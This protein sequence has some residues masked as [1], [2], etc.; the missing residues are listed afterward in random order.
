MRALNI[1][2]S[3]LDAIFRL[4]L[5]GGVSSRFSEFIRCTLNKIPQPRLQF[6]VLLQQFTNSLIFA[7]P[8]SAVLIWQILLVSFEIT[9]RLDTQ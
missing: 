1:L 8:G 2:L 7:C 6:A 9:E 4:Y 5:Y 3:G